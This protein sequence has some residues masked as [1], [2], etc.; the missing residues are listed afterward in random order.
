VIP[1]ALLNEGEAL[2]LN[3]LKEHVT[4]YVGICTSQPGEDDTL[5]TITELSDIGY[6]R[7]PVTFGAVST[8]ANGTYISNSATIEFG[9][10]A[11]E[12][13]IQYY[14]ITDTASGTNGYLIFG[15]AFTQPKQ[16]G[17]NDTLVIPVGNLKLYAS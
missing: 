12:H 14:L 16:V 4:M 2:I 7:K 8:D 13:T 3:L 15:G 1:V 9:P 17:E 10:F 11:E 6:S 5:E